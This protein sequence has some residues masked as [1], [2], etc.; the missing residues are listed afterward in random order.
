MENFINIYLR[1]AML[2]LEQ[3]NRDVAKILCQKY[4]KLNDNLK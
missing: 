4:K 2:A 1:K 3:G